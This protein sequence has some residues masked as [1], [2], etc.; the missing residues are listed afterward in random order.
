MLP[1]SLEIKY[2]VKIL[3]VY[4]TLYT[5]GRIFWVMTKKSSV[6]AFKIIIRLFVLL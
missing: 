1:A 3:V 2:L 6:T 4:A 5:K